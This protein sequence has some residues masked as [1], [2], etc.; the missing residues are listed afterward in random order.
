GGAF[1]VCD[2]SSNIYS[3]PID[4]SKYG[5]IYAGAQKNLGPAGCALVIMRKD[6]IEAGNEDL[7]TIV[8]YRTHADGDSRYN[9]PNTFAIYLM[10]QVF[11]W[12]KR[13]GGLA[14]IASHNERKAGVLYDYLDSSGFYRATVTDASSRSLMNIC[15]R[16]VNEELEPTFIAEAERA[17]L[18][19]LKGH[20]SV[21]GMRASVYNALPAEAVDALIAFMKEFERTHG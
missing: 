21:G 17:G 12:I 15:F 9:T 1:L 5:L 20:R 19:N 4:V 3:K 14:G 8:Q 10:G 16:C 6:L 13:E 7:P 11:K 18:K 2:A